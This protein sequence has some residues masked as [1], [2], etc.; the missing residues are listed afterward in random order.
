MTVETKSGGA[1]IGE[2]ADGATAQ[3]VVVAFG[4]LAASVG[5]IRSETARDLRTLQASPAI[6]AP[7]MPRIAPSRPSAAAVAAVIV[8]RVRGLAPV[9]VRGWGGRGLGGG[10]LVGRRVAGRWVVA[11]CGLIAGRVAAR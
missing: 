6:T 5:L 10:G 8:R 1:S 2:I 11:G 3:G 4:V 7:A 9:A